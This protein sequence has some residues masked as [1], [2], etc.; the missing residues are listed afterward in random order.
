MALRRFRRCG[1]GTRRRWRKWVAGN[2]LPSDGSRARGFLWV[3][4][5][6]EFAIIGRVEVEQ[7]AAGHEVL[8]KRHAHRVGGAVGQ[9]GT[10]TKPI[11]LPN[12][13]TPLVRLAAPMPLLA[14]M[15]VP[16]KP[17]TT[18]LPRF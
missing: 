7:G 17:A 15:S 11:K 18:A 13:G 4:C 16:A 3:G 1:G 8:H 12:R 5:L 2:S 9:R 10:V 6:D 14:G